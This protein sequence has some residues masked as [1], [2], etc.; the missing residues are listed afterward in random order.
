MPDRDVDILLYGA[1]GFVGSRVAHYLA[2]AAP[3][4][5]LRFA[6]AGRDRRQLDGVWQ[7]IGGAEADVP[8]MSVD[9]RDQASVDAAVARA[10]VVLNTAGPF[11]LYGTPV[12]DA[13]VR[14][15][16]HYVD[17]TGETVWIRDLIDRY[18]YRAAQAGIRIVPGCGFASVP[19]DIGTLL[20]VRHVQSELDA[21]CAEVKAFFKASG[22]INGGS[23]ATMIARYELGQTERS[24]DPFLLDP[25]DAHDPEEVQ[26]NRDPTSARYDEDAGTWVGPFIMAPINTRIVRRSAAL[27]GRWGKPY[28]P[29]FRYQEFARYDPPLARAKAAAAN[30]GMALVDVVFSREAGRRVVKRLARKPGEGPS[31]KT[32]KEGWFTTD[33]IATSADGRKSR[34][35]LEFRGDPGN[36]ATALFVSEAAFALASDFDRLPT[37]DARGGLLTPAT[38]LGGRYAERLLAAGLVARLGI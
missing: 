17:I 25:P 21:P 19:S 9:S 2:R 37:G 38:G 18:H 22:G 1:T 27:S 5:G 7:R 11:A 31:E 3:E 36:R 8:L 13:C 24:R 12:V 28:G 32:M 26:Q 34:A 35:R 30:S 6:L 4:N 33:L 29:G 23:V 10:R 14:L 15:G 20:L 16:T